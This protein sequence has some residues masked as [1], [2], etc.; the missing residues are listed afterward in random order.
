LGAA[1]LGD[2]GDL[3]PDENETWRDA[4]SVALLAAVTTRVRAEGWQ[5]VN[6][7]CVVALEA[8]KLAAKRT[9]MQDRL[10]EAVGADVSVKASRPEGLGALG[11]GEGVACWA[12]ALVARAP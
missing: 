10:A 1:C 2:I 5:P 7:D 3:F 9:A 6:V 11:R 4:D 8:P 12:V